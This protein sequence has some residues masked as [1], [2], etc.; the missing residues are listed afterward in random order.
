MGRRRARS[1]WRLDVHGRLRLDL[2]AASGNDQRVR[3]L[4][5]V[6]LRS[7]DVV[8]A[9]R[10]DVGWLRAVGLGAVSLR[11]LGVSQQRVGVGAA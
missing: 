1:V 8:S 9:I 10:L 2:A 11:S 4:G 3:R 7:L 6:S 5:A